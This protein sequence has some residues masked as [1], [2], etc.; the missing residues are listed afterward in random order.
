MRKFG[1]LSVFVL[2]FFIYS[3]TGFARSEG[4]L[5]EYQ[6]LFSLDVG[7]TNNKDMNDEVKKLAQDDMEELKLAPLNYSNFSDSISKGNLPVGFDL[8]FRYFND[9]FGIGLQ[10]GYHLTKA[11]SEL[12]ASGSPGYSPVK[13]TSTIELSVVPV[14]VTLFYRFESDSSNSFVLVGGGL[15]YYFGTISYDWKMTG[16]GTGSDSMPDFKQS[17]IGFHILLE[18]DYAFDF[19]LTLFG[20]IKARYVQFNEFKD[21]SY[22]LEN[23]KHEKFKAGLT[24]VSLYLGA[25]ASF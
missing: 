24:G 15:G 5:P 18:Y 11:E 25:G 9:N 16:G 21:G 14:V 22:Y 17:K 20:G 12:S 13:T 4:Q 23:Y 8:D 19:G 10:V 6:L 3:A 1:F 7:W 2:I